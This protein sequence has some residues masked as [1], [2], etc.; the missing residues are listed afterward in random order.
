MNHAIKGINT[1]NKAFLPV[2]DNK[3]INNLN[4]IQNREF[5]CNWHSI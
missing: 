2:L 5:C 4:K 1:V 3:G